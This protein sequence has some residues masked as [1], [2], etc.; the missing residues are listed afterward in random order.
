[1]PRSGSALKPRAHT[2]P[3]EGLFWYARLVTATSAGNMFAT[4]SDSAPGAGQ[5]LASIQALRA[6]AATSVVVFHTVMSLSPAWPPSVLAGAYVWGKAGVDLFFVISGFIMVTTTASNR[7]VGQFLRARIARIVPLYWVLTLAMAAMVAFGASTTAT[8]SPAHLAASLAFYPWL[9]ATSVNP[10]LYVGWTLNYEAFFYAVFALAM[11]APRT[12]LMPILA[13]AFS[14]LALGSL[15]HPTTLQAQFYT[16]PIT[17]EFVMGAAVGA[18]F[19]QGRTPSAR[20]GALLLVAG[21]AA[22]AA[23]APLNVVPEWRVVLWGLPS[24]A[25]VAGAVAMERAGAWPRLGPAVLVGDASY[26]IYLSHAMMLPV[27]VRLAPHL[28]GR[29]PGDVLRLAM[30]GACLAGGVAIWR[31]VERP[32]SSQARALLKRLAPSREQASTS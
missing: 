1:M 24:T 31:F 17:L 10:V 20:T 12:W 25:I 21:L 3:D 22:I 26:A 32:L 28:V 14:L 29:V 15:A 27:L 5:R 4:T 16:D 19:R 23:T 9:T 6:L 8:F 30:V 11:L 18:V 7:G 13:A 2:F